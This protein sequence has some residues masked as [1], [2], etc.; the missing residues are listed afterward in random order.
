MGGTK[1]FVSDAARLELA[2]RR[3]NAIRFALLSLP[4]HTS[5]V[6]FFEDEKK[7]KR[8]RGAH[9]AEEEDILARS[10]ALIS[11]KSP[12]K[13]GEQNARPKVFFF[14]LHTRDV[15]TT[16]TVKISTRRTA[17]STYRKSRLARSGF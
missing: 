8:R 14:S 11:L 1:R 5:E 6:F 3:S 9:R 2:T 7:N 17:Q 15:E 12:R 10:M 4:T 16:R 13:L